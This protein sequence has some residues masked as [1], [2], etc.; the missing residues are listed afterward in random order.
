[1]RI[2]YHQRREECF[3]TRPPP[4]QEDPLWKEAEGLPIGGFEEQLKEIAALL[5]EEPF[6]KVS[7]IKTRFNG[8][9]GC[10]EFF[11][12][13]G[14]GTDV[15]IVAQFELMFVQG[16]LFGMIVR[17]SLG[18]EAEVAFSDELSVKCSFEPL[19]EKDAI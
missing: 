8:G 3:E 13:K 16:Q 11:V 1:M 15:Q 14:A 9:N 7:K 5:S 12:E 2:E 10:A 19:G 18:P 17:S 6:S 4:R